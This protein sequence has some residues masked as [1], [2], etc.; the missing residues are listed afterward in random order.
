[1][2]GSREKYSIRQFKLTF[3]FFI[4]ALILGVTFFLLLAGSFKT[5]QSKVSI[6]FIPKSDK[7]SIH[8]PYILKNLTKFPRYLSFYERVLSDNEN[9]N[10]PFLGKSK[11]ERKKLWNESLDIKQNGNSAIIYIKVTQKDQ[12]VLIAKQT[13]RTLFDT[14]SRYYNIKTDIDLRIIEGPNTIAVL[15][16]WYWL[17]LLSAVLGFAVSFLLN[18]IFFGFFKFIKENR[19]NFNLKLKKGEKQPEIKKESLKIFNIPSVKIET[20]TKRSQAPSNLPVAEKTLPISEED[21]SNILPASNGFTTEVLKEQKGEGLSEPSEDELKERLNQL[22][23][24]EM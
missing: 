1:M 20:G 6:L 11:D 13:A 8:A 22:L 10:D 21:L 18:F 7:A 5:Y 4:L 14:A 12:S 2:F 3:S 24:G 9:I 16:H 19:I 23:K 17:V 15:K